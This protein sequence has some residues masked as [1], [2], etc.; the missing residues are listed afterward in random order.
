MGR[1]FLR[2]ACAYR[3]LLSHF[4]PLRLSKEAEDDVV[5]AEGFLN[6]K[7]DI[8]KGLGQRVLRIVRLFSPSPEVNIGSEAELNQGTV[9]LFSS[10]MRNKC[11]DNC[12]EET[13]VFLKVLEHARGGLV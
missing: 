4:I 3:L 11:F 1:G 9:S 12:D 10:C 13:A 5:T 8:L 7:V 6:L 2:E